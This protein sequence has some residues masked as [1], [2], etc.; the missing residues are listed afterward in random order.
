M[1]SIITTC[2]RRDSPSD[3]AVA[4]AQ[5]ESELRV[6]QRERLLRKNKLGGQ[7]HENK[8]QRRVH[9]LTRALG[10]AAT[11]YKLLSM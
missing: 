9:K 10:C 8:A 2:L 7:W 1:I 5:Q 4:T 6:Q 3:S 11:Y